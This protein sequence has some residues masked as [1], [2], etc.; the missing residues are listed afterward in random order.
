MNLSQLAASQLG[1]GFHTLRGGIDPGDLQLV[2]VS[3]SCG[4]VSTQGICVFVHGLL[5]LYRYGGVSEPGMGIYLPRVRR[6]LG[7]DLRGNSRRAL[8]P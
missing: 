6:D 2:G 8:A 3:T 4:A 5:E 7:V 1:W